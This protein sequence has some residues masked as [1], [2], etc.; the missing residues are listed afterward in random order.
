MKKTIPILKSILSTFIAT[1]VTS[2][3]LLASEKPSQIDNSAI[4]I[5][6]ENG[7]HIIASILLDGK[8]VTQL[9]KKAVKEG[10]QAALFFKIPSKV[11]H[12]K[13][14]GTLID[15]QGDSKEF[16]KTWRLYDLAKYTAPLYNQALPWVERVKIFSEQIDTIHIE[17]YSQKEG[18]DETPFKNLE[19]QLNIKLPKSIYGLARYKID[20]GGGSNASFFHKAHNIRS[21]ANDIVEYWGE[22]YI[23]SEE[24]A[25]F[26]RSIAVFSY[27]GD[28]SR[29]LAWDPVGEIQSEHNKSITYKEGVWFWV[30]NDSV[31]KRSLMLD[32]DNKPLSTEETLNSVFHDYAMYKFFDPLAETHKVLENE[33]II[34][35]NM[36][37]ANFRLTFKRD[38][39]LTPL[40]WLVL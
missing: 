35:S 15:A 9:D 24:R 6:L 36:P 13:L 2:T 19:K 23:P 38:K 18:L 4:S 33:L 7:E 37:H 26:E 28:S 14:Y 16:S 10:Y 5:W 27:I 11:K 31:G 17:P 21:L 30:S 40:L 20:I 25:V 12:L 34:D 8:E 1:L 39:E 29:F 32:W 22:A 3:T